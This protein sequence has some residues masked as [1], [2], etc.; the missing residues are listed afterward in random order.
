[1][2]GLVLVLRGNAVWRV[3]EESEDNVCFGLPSE[4]I[5]SSGE[6]LFFLN[7]CYYYFYTF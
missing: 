4:R 2:K 1:M 3:T 6:V 7:Y 5:G